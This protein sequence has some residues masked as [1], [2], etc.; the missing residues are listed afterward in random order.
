MQDS[1]QSHTSQANKHRYTAWL[2]LLGGLLIAYVIAMFIANH[3]LEATEQVIQN[4]LLGQLALVSSIAE[5]TARNGADAVTESI[6]QNCPM[7]ELS[8]YNS[9]LSSLD[10]GLNAAELA[11]VEQL[12]SRCGGFNAERKAAMVARL[13]R[14]TEILAQYADQLRTLQGSD[15]YSLPIAKWEQLVELE[16]TQQVLFTDLVRLQGEIITALRAGD[17]ITSESI[18][19]I[20]GRVQDAR[21]GLELAKTQ[22]DTLRQ[23]LTSL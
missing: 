5:I 10:R 14:E 20:L 21:D 23:Q 17:T 15:E 8:R 13:D 7:Q 3:R 2:F 19:A 18:V 22:T 11:E 16:Q 12:H 6:V 1:S 4:Q 9:L